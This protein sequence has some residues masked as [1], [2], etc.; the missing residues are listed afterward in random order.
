MQRDL[1]DA[2]Y[3]LAVI[4]PPICTLSYGFMAEIF[5]W[6][7][8]KGGDP[9][10]APLV[11][12]LWATVGYSTPEYGPEHSSPVVIPAS[13]RSLMHRPRQIM[14]GPLL[15]QIQS[16]PDQTT[17]LWL[18]SISSGDSSQSSSLADGP[19]AEAAAGGRQ[20]VIIRIR[21]PSVFKSRTP[22]F[23][24]TG[25]FTSLFRSGPRPLRKTI[26]Q[27]QT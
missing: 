17:L 16:S 18:S 12:K 14:F 5:T 24:D 1:A 10:T 7:M 27:D 20:R 2:G 26:T 21:C 15:F 22:D 6:H 9:A 3:A 19:F 25:L 23:L 11:C 8:L 13:R 4:T